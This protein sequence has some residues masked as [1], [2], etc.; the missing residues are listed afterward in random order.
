MVRAMTAAFDAPYAGAFTDARMAT[1]EATMTMD[2]PGRPRIS[3]M[4]NW[5]ARK[6]PS[7]LTAK[8]LRQVSRVVLSTDMPGCRNAAQLTRMSNPP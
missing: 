2:A 6:L 3:G 7:A 1:P 5:H 4:A 8:V